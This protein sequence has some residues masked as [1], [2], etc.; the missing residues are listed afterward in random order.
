MIHIRAIQPTDRAAWQPL[1]DG[2]NAFYGR[3][4]EAALPVPVTETTWARFFDAAEPVYALVAV[5]EHGALLGL[6]H[7]LYHRSTTR[8]EP[9]CYLQD[10]FTAPEARGRGV[11]RALIEGVYAAAREADVKRVY[12]QTHT[13]NAA[14]RALY[15]KLAEHRGFIVYGHD[16]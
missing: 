2:Y 3:A 15:D 10:L 5:D 14:G 12:W 7:Y 11:G 8:I 1:W 9:T 13:T 4:G 16:V 6:V